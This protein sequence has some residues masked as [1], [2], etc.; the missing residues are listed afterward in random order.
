MQ[1][2]LFEERDTTQTV[3]GISLVV[4]GA[5]FAVPYGKP[6]AARSYR[7]ETAVV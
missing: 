1:V 5:L 6:Q 4:A 7:G 3:L 2:T